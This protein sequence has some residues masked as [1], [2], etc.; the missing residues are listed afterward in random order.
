MNKIRL[1]LK[2]F[3]LI[4]CSLVCTSVARAQVVRTFV[5]TSG[6]DNASCSR[7]SPC[8]T[9][10]AAIAAVSTDGE[11][12]VLDSGG[13]GSLTIMKGVTI[14]S[15]PAIHAAIAP[16]SGDAITVSA[17]GSK[18]YL[19]GLML[20]GQ[21]GANGINVTAVDSLYIE[22]TIIQNFT[23]IGVNFNAA[24]F[25]FVEDTNVRKCAGGGIS[26]GAASGT[27]RASVNRARLEQNLFG[28]KVNPRGVAMARE[29]FASGNTDAGFWAAGA[30]V[31]TATPGGVL[32]LDR[33]TAHR[34]AIGIKQT[35]HQ[36]VNPNQDAANGAGVL[37]TFNHCVTVNN[38]TFDLS[39]EGDFTT[40]KSDGTN[41]A[42][43]VSN[44][45]GT[46]TTSG[47]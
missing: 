9:F 42:E 12:V 21:G 34:N 23:G 16:T 19:K 44:L 39:L 35:G 26:V 32:A 45:S 3:A 6:V 30:S 47:F 40:I 31:P 22:H 17:P 2:V 10:T 38:T 15:P 25:L 1:T 36:T 11:V 29:T 37:K 4:A 7:T 43:T 8:R 18:V 14:V 27:A 41:R 33:C 28:V 20:N 5:S 46:A 24:G 13:Y